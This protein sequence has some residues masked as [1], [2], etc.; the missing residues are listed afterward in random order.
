MVKA[1]ILLVDQDPALVRLC[2]QLL[3]RASYRVITAPDLFEGL[4]VIAEQ[5]VDLLIADIGMPG[6]DGIKL[7]EQAK[8][9]Q[10][11]LPVLVMT[12]YDH[13]ENAIQALHRGADRLIIKPFKH[14]AELVQVVSLTL[15]ASR[16]KRAANRVH[17]LRP[18]FDVSERLLAETS[19]ETVEILIADTIKDLFEASILEQILAHFCTDQAGP[20]VARAARPGAEP[21]QA[22]RNCLHLASRAGL[23]SRQQARYLEMT[24]VENRSSAECNVCLGKQIWLDLHTGIMFHIFCKLRVSTRNL[25]KIKYT[26]HTGSQFVGLTIEDS[27]PGIS[28]DLQDQIFEPFVSTKKK[29]TGLELAVSFGIIEQH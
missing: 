16:Q 25:Q 2:Q 12:G 6:M 7:V 14:P 4:Q 15:H 10:P 9:S 18:L 8:Q 29:G 26:I 3:E 27:G 23:D 11:A 24:G 17:T 19:P 22:V 5:C 28:I 21:L 1:T 13:I 20:L